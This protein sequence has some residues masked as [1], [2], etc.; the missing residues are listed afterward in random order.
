MVKGM[1]RVKALSSFYA[2]I[3]ED[4]RI[5]P[6]HIS[7]YMAIFQL[8]N[9]NGFVNPVHANR[10]LLMDMAKIAGLA[11]FHKCIKELHEF[12]YVQYMASHDHRVMSK[13]FLLPIS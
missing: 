2:A 6:T 4:H 11:T 8:Y 10:A 3:R 5:G 7:L 1:E 9:L 12:G 13:I